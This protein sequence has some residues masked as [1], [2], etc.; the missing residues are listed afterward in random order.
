MEVVK[1]DLMMCNLF[2]DLAQDRSEC[3]NIIYVAQ[4]S[5]DKALMMMMVMRRIQ[6]DELKF[7]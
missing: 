7:E 5:W 3:R 6:L 2:E 4:Y 1:I